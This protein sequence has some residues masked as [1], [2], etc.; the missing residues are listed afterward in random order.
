MPKTR[1]LV[2]ILAAAFCIMLA[3]A[4]KSDARAPQ[5]KPKRVRNVS[6]A[7]KSKLREDK[8]A[9]KVL[10]DKVLHHLQRRRDSLIE[11]DAG[12]RVDLDSI[13]E[14]KL[15]DFHDFAKQHRNTKAALTAKFMIGATLLGAPRGE[16]ALEGRRCLEEVAQDYPDTRE[17]KFAENYLIPI[18]DLMEEE[19]DPNV[20]T[21]EEDH[22]KIVTLLMEYR[23][24]I[25]KL[26][27]TAREI[28]NDANDTSGAFRTWFLGGRREKIEPALRSLLASLTLEMGEKKEAIQIYRSIKKDY[29]NSM[30]SRD[31]DEALST[32]KWLEEHGRPVDGRLSGPGIRKYRKVM[33][34]RKKR[35][36]AE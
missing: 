4:A 10:A 11:M 13:K 33:E 18:L 6:I 21:V 19:L 26:L 27:P 2:V 20:T 1:L 28:D 12:K 22:P 3:E 30:S 14:Q 17:A 9:S 8:K 16:Q 36:L 24:G 5:E 34:Q 15:L 35:L 23:H 31:A 25:K 29:P 32:I 7:P